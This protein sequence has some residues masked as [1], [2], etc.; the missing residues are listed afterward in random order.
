MTRGKKIKGRKRHILVDTLGLVIETLVHSAGI[1]D[2]VGARYLISKAAV[3][4][5]YQIGELNKVW[6]DGGYMG[7]L[8]IG[9]KDQLICV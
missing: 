7:T 8:L 3:H 6:V 5:Q 9:L 2:R 1:Q 4:H